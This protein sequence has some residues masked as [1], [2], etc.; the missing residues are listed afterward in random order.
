[1]PDNDRQL[2]AIVP[3]TGKPPENSIMFGEMPQVM[4]NIPQ[5]VARLEAEQRFAQVKKDAEETERFHDEVRARAA[6][7]LGD[8]LAH[9]SNRLDGYEARKAERADQ[10]RR[11][12][13]EAEAAATEEFLASLPD[14]DS[15]RGDD[16]EFEIK[17]PPDVEKYN[18]EGEARLESTTGETPAEL[19]ETVPPEPGQY[20]ST[21]PPE[22]P[23]R[24]PGLIGGP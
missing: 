23:Y 8:G 17:P 6:Q 16:G 19:E 1:M 2:V 22:G 14:P 7:I 3:Y 21:T 20:L 18:P 24:N 12:E 13:E 9:L 10:Q 15:P 11:E 5:S 4:E